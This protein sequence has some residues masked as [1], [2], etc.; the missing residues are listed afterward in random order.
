MGNLRVQINA[1][2]ED[3][4]LDDLLKWPALRGLGHIPLQNVLVRDTGLQGHVDS[5]ATA[6]TQ[7]A[8]DNDPGQTACLSLA[9]AEILL[10]VRD[11]RILVRVAL[12]SGQGLAGVGQLPG[13]VLQ[14]QGG[15]AEAGGVSEGGDAT[16]GGRVLQE[17]KVEEGAAAARESGQ[18]GL[19][20][21]LLLV[22][23]GKLNMDVLKGDW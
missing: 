9:L 15:A 16:S 3:V 18:D 19:P 22:T 1:V 5:S 17:L 11:Q 23:M 21:A 13:P 20:P 6:P 8:N 7:R 14:G 2:Y 12:H 4:A 10:D